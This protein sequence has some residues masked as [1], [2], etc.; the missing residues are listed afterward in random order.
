MPRFILVPCIIAMYFPKLKYLLI[1]VF[2]LVL[3]Y[4][5][6]MSIQITAMSNLGEALIIC[7]LD[8]RVIFLKKFVL[9]ITSL[10]CWENEIGVGELLWRYGIPSILRYNLDCGRQGDMMLLTFMLSI[11]LIYFLTVSMSDCR[12]NFVCCDYDIFPC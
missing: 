3:F 11:F 4:K 1:M 6:Y 10:I 9:W 2:A 5:S 12:D 7:S 8:A